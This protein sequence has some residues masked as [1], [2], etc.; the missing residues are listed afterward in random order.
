MWKLTFKTIKENPKIL[1]GAFGIILISLLS[2]IPYYITMFQTDFVNNGYASLFTLEYLLILVASLAAMLVIVPP[3][4]H[5][6]YEVCAKI[7]TTGWYMRGLKQNWWRPFV[8]YLIGIV[9]F[10]VVGGCMFIIMLIPIIGIFA[11]FIYMAAAFTLSLL[12]I[13]G[14]S[15]VVIE[16]NFG[17]GLGNIFVVGKK[18]FFKL[19]GASAAAYAPIIILSI[20]YIVI[21]IISAFGYYDSY[22]V[23]N[24]A[25][26]S[27]TGIFPT[28]FLITS[29]IYFGFT[30]LYSPFVTTFI[31]TFNTHQYLKN[32]ALLV[33]TTDSA[34]SDLS[35]DDNDTTT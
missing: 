5:Y 20:I 2:A 9:A 23:T 18:Y 10:T 32:R 25:H 1:L 3:F 6:I 16:K 15:A 31:F 26:T 28:N 35:P 27:V 12:L 19:L 22:A 13:I 11:F 29:A 7:D 30:M 24:L 33:A 14:A 21:T 8:L 4:L 34:A 17:T